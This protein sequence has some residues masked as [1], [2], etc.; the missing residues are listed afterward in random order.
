MISAVTVAAERHRPYAA[1]LQCLSDK[2]TV[3]W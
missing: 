1:M 3:L 2:S